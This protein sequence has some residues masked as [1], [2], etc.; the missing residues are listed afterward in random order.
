MILGR[1]PGDKFTFRLF[2]QLKKQIPVAHS[3]LYLWSTKIDIGNKNT[4][5]NLDYNKHSGYL[6]LVNRIEIL[7]SIKEN[8]VLIGI[9]DHLTSF[10]FNPF[11]QTKPDIVEYLDNMFEFYKDKN[12]FLCTSLENL[13]LYINR[14]NVKIIPWGGDIT[15]HQDEYLKLS[16]CLEKNLSSKK[17][18][19]SLNRN[20]RY[21][22]YFLLS[23]IFGLNIEDNGILSCHFEDFDY[24]SDWIY[25]KDQLSIKQLSIKGTK[26][27][28]LY[29]NYIQDN[30][31]IYENSDNNNPNNFT[32]KLLNYYKNTFVEIIS[33]TSCT[34]KC[35]NLTEKTLNSIYGCS[36]PIL[37]SSKGTVNFLREIGFD[38]FDDIVDHSYDNIDNVIDRIHTAITAN[39]ELLNNNERTKS[40]WS[41]SKDRFIKNIEIARNHMYNYYELR[42]QD[43]FRKGLNEFNL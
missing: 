32:N 20:K 13:D 5:Y 33:E 16:P 12:I 34:E 26:L 23:L 14:P 39:F 37:I 36:F 27:V 29:D 8:T 24:N 10:H 22:R 28:E 3:S 11:Q 9:K 31:E 2:F 35:F 15:N 43:L 18:F 30:R 19:L 42:A 4:I 1:P 41:N 38:V 21:H 7:K 6:E 17:T 25:T 40:L